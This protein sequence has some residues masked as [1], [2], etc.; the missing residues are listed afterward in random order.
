MLE[1]GPM[2]VVKRCKYSINISLEDRIGGSTVLHNEIN[3]SVADRGPKKIPDVLHGVIQ[4]LLK[5]FLNM[6]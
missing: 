2:L 4:F 1:I 5:E 3:D 6:T